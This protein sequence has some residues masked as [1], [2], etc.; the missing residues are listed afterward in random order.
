M[1]LCIEPLP[2][3]AD[4]S[5]YGVVMTSMTRRSL[6]EARHPATR[7]QGQDAARQAAVV[8]ATLAALVTAAWGMGAFGGVPIA[9]AQDGALAADASLLAPA[10]PAFAVWGP[11]YL[12]LA[13]YAIWQFLPARRAQHRQRVVGWWIA[14]LAAVEAIWIAVAQQGPL[15]LVLA[16]MWL[17]VLI[18]AIGWRSA[19]VT[20]QRRSPWLDL[21]LIE[22][23]VGLTFGWALL[24]AVAV[25]AGAA[26]RSAPATWE[27]NGRMF[28]L[29]VVAAVL[30]VG[31][32][33][34]ALSGWRVSVPIAVGWGIG[35]VGFGRLEG[36]PVDAVVGWCALAAAAALV[37]IPIVLR[38]RVLLRG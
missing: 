37:V 4:Q 3:R 23:L 10:G 35:W 36:Q 17:L 34:S 24:A 16:V 25:T 8:V 29:I 26:T 13:G 2:P 31:L 28:A 22:G 11:L 33:V 21:I 38:A 18:A 1:P 9:D 30:V 12:L 6:R 15:W 14:G 5:S 32:G 20:E 27:Q 19:I 7:M